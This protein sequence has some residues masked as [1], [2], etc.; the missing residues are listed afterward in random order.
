MTFKNVGHQIASFA[1]KFVAFMQ[2]D[3]SKII[4]TAEADKPTIDTVTAMLGPQAQ[5]IETAAYA[6][7]GFVGQGLDSGVQAIVDEFNKLDATVQT[8]IKA[9]IALVKQKI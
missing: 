5:T 9:A 2:N 4:A 3:V 6:A 8:D 7:L 1:K